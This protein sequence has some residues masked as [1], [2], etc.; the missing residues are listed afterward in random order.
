[1]IHDNPAIERGFSFLFARRAVLLDG[2][3]RLGGVLRS[4]AR[5]RA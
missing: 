2:V 5:V 3:R 4:A 1:M